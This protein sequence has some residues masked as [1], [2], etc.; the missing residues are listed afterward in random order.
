MKSLKTML[1]LLGMSFFL[2][3]YAL[4][5]ELTGKDLFGKRLCK[6]CHGEK[7]QKP[8]FN[9]YPALAGNSSEYLLSQM[10]AIKNGTRNNRYAEQMRL[11]IEG[12]GV[13]DQELGKIAKWL[14]KQ[15]M[16][17]TANQNAKGKALFTKFNCNTC[18]GADGKTSTAPIYP[19]LAGNNAGYLLNQMIDIKNKHRVGGLTATMLPFVSKVSDKDLKIMA[20]WLGSR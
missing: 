19:S 16:V 3:G 5:E 12:I 9:G 14:S 15:A 10:K 11:A 7:G 18:H 8:L 13:T 6:S 4:A 1:L 17:A 2:S 20:D